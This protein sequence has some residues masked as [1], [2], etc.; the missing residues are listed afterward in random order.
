M[1]AIGVTIR[2]PQR[3]R[4]RPPLSGKDVKP[5][6]NWQE[7]NWVELPEGTL[8]VYFHTAYQRWF[9]LWVLPAGVNKGSRLVLAQRDLGAPL[10]LPCCR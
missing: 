7:F 3:Q 5:P 9:Y 10:V 4:R 1:R 2:A 8:G 6:Y